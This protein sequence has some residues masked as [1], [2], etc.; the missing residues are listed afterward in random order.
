M[1]VAA[2]VVLHRPG[3]VAQQVLR[4]WIVGPVAPFVVVAAAVVEVSFAVDVVASIGNGSAIAGAN[5][6]VEASIQSDSAAGSG[7]SVVAVVSGRNSAK[8]VSVERIHP[9]LERLLP[10]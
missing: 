4:Y 1:A 5:V 10:L 7:A 3:K 9:E 2:V 8:E 6:A